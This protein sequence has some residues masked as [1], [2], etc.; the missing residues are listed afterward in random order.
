MNR[1]EIIN[2]I[3]SAWGVETYLEIGVQTGKNFLKVAAPKK[4]A[5]DPE[6]KIKL[7]RKIWYFLSW[8]KS[9]FFEMTSDDFFNNR[10]SNIFKEKPL[11]VAFIDGLHT[12]EQSFR[13]F[14]NCFRH[15]SKNGIIMFHDCNPDSFEAAAPAFSP[16]DMKEKFP[17]K[18]TYE[19][20]GDVW[21]SIVRLR[22]LHPELEVFTL[23]C[24]YGIGVVRRGKP[25]DMLSYTLEEI[26]NLTYADLKA[27][28]KR[29]LNLKN[30]AYLNEFVQTL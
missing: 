12:Y 15:L 21:K 3:N 16:Q 25:H 7:K 9:R 8:I 10:A 28:R 22:S 19:W 24:D 17:K 13:D 30:A 18:E 11:D 26:D 20:N 5:V 23:D 4:I 1:K 29:F 14:E 6:F 2:R 27:D